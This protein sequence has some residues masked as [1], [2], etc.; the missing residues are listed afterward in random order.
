[1][2]Q[3]PFAPFALRE[4]VLPH[5]KHSQSKTHPGSVRKEAGQGNHKN[6]SEEYHFVATVFTR[7]FKCQKSLINQ[8]QSMIPILVSELHLLEKF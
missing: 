4:T 7:K 2:F 8:Y 5:R 6:N 3:H 1:M